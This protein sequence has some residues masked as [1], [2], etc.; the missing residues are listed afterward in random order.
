MQTTKYGLS[1]KEQYV[2]WVIACWFNAPV[3]Q[4]LKEKLYIK[5]PFS[6]QKTED[7]DA[8]IVD[9]IIEIGKWLEIK[10]RKEANATEND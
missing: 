4:T 3:T 10:R 5:S 2:L 8:Q 9:R 7:I 6:K 1:D